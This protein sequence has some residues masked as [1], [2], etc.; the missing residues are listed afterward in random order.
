MKRGNSGLYAF[1][2]ILLNSPSVSIKWPGMGHMDPTAIGVK[3][4]VIIT[5]IIIFTGIILMHIADFL[6]ILR[7]KNA[8]AP[9]NVLLHGIGTFR[10][11]HIATL[12]C[13]LMNMTICKNILLTFAA[14]TA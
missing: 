14:H 5:M 11:A 6:V 1:I 7:V 10:N 9:G 8:K 12:M 4:K 13:G 2:I 3:T